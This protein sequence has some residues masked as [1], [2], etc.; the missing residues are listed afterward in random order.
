MAGLDMFDL[1]GPE[2]R[3]ASVCFD[4]LVDAIDRS[5]AAMVCVLKA[6][7]PAAMLEIIM[8]AMERNNEVLR[9]YSL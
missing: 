4:A 1:H 2:F 7:S 3:E 8:D 5:N 6:Q 9:K